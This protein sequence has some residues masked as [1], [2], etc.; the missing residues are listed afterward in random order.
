VNGMHRWFRSLL[1]AILR[2]GIVTAGMMLWLA[3]PAYAHGDMAG[4]AV[5]GPPLAVSGTLAVIFYWLVMLW[6][7]RPKNEGRDDEPDDRWPGG[8]GPPKDG[9]PLDPNP[10]VEKVKLKIV[11]VYTG[12]RVPV[13]AGSD[14]SKGVDH[15][16]DL[17]TI[18]FGGSALHGGNS[19]GRVRA[20]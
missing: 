5:L 17:V 4:P 6:P 9:L 19:T 16:E 7:S 2:Y 12:D 8:G 18:H 3:V 1:R 15:E 20:R 13:L 14:D 11:K 10:K